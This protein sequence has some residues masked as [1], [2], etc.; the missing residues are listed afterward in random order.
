M[1]LLDPLRFPIGSPQVK[2]HLSDSERS[3][4]IDQIESAPALLRQAVAGLNDSQLD[5]P[6]RS[7]GWTVRQVVH[8]IP[9]SHLNA[10]IRFRWALTEDFPK[11][12]A[13]NQDAWAHLADACYGPVEESLALLDALHPRW[14]RLMRAMS[15]HDWQSK[16]MHPEDGLRTCE[17]FLIIYAWHGCH[18]IAHITGLR[19]RE[20][21]W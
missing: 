1:R 6:Y 20:K 11:I 2:K 3:K 5:T 13:Y 8:H 12:K 16:V 10:Y 17:D 15:K 4:L 18:H 7:N 21:W 9:D 19:D 14:C